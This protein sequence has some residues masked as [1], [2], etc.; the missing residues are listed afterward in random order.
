MTLAPAVRSVCCLGIV[1]VGTSRVIT[2][3]KCSMTN[4]YSNQNRT[5]RQKQ[6]RGRIGG[7]ANG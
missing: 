7:N 6:D 5:E 1:R 3:I 4:D 2:C